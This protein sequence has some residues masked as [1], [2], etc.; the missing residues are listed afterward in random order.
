[1]SG[2][3]NPV[4]GQKGTSKT[5]DNVIRFAVW[6]RDDKT[7][8]P[9]AGWKKRPP[10]SS[11]HGVRNEWLDRLPKMAHASLLTDLPDIDAKPSRLRSIAA[12]LL[13]F[14]EVPIVTTS[15]VRETGEP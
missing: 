15:D 4:L 10:P 5:G 13:H 7:G 1:V 11:S 12:N 8:N 9:A 6:T 3:V 2:P 14:Q